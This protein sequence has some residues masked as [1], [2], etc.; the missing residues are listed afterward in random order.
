MSRKLLANIL[1]KK[2]GHDGDNNIY[3]WRRCNEQ[4][5]WLS[6]SESGSAGVLQQSLLEGELNACLLLSGTDVVCQQV[7]FNKQEKKHLAKLI[8]FEMEEDLTDELDELHFAF[9]ALE[10][11]QAVAAYTDSQQLR[12]V[13]QELE[14]AGL[15]INHCLPEPILIERLDNGWG[16]RLD[17]YLHVHYGNGLGFSVDLSLAQPALSGLSQTHQPQHLLLLGADPEKLQQLRDLLPLDLT[18]HLVEE[19]IDTKVV[20]EWESL[21]LSTIDDLDLRQG[22]FARQLPLAKWWQE[23]RGVSIVAGVAL[24]V[25]LGIS[26]AQVQINNAKELQ[27]RQEMAQ[28]YRQVVP[29]GNASANMEE[30]LRRRLE[31]YQGG[32]SGGSVVAMLA[33]V[34]PMI[35]KKPDISLQNMRY[36]DQ[37]GTMDLTLTAKSSS[38]GLNLGNDIQTTGL[39]A[40][41]Q[42]VTNIGDEVQIR[43]TIARAAL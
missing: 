2:I 9:G 25:F 21:Q 18:Q 43:M 37:R 40:K 19:Q 35:A 29:Q 32:S 39:S 4:G 17:D 34:A 14:A 24:L 8:P 31:T 23:W 15:L 6:N 13:L 28:V 3:T 20:D 22:Q 30:I 5:R 1:I 38:D 11:E 7:N 12:D 41:V 27:I 36:D 26:I 42:G 10:D 16:L 33:K